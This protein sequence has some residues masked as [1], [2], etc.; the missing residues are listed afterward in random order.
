MGQKCGSE[1]LKVARIT[2][3]TTTPMPMVAK[4]CGINCKNRK[5][6]KKIVQPVTPGGYPKRSFYNVKINEK[7][8]NGQMGL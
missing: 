2:Y 5:I 3:A 8:A 6:T 4:L 7:V 1:N